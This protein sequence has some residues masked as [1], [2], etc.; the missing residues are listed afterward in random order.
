M[1]PNKLQSVSHDAVQSTRGTLYQLWVAVEKCYEMSQAGQSIF[2]EFQGDVTSQGEEQIE[3]KCYTDPLTDNHICFWK[4][5]RNWMQP[6]FSPENYTSLIL[7]TTQEFGPKATIASW[8]NSTN[9]LGIL[10]AIHEKA[11]TRYK[12]KYEDKQGENLPSPPKTL[13]LQR[14]VMALKHEE[15]LK[16]ILSRFFIEANSPDLQDLCDKIK[17][18]YLKGILEGKKD[19]FLN[20]L[21]GFVTKPECSP[22]DRWKIT[23]EEFT[24]KNKELTTTYCR[25]TKIFPKVCVEDEEIDSHPDE[26]LFVKK[27]KDIDHHEVIRTAIE[28]YLHALKI[29]TE[30]FRAYSVPQSRTIDY[31]RSLVKKFKTRYRKS[32]R[33]CANIIEESKDFYD[34]TTSENPLPFGGFDTTSMDFRNGLLHSQMNDEEKGLMW[35]LDSNE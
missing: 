28:E 15:R 8:N 3:V 21:F 34:I 29:T 32:S 13:C 22:G 33:N 24:E 23:Y 31:V 17:G 10:K 12:K 14:E 16:T 11:E 5:L 9:K 30:E 19:D 18:Q 20:A 1:S 27:I 6:E 2:I 7:Y 25:D 26:E 35:R 4:T